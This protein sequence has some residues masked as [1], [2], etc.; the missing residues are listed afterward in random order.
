MHYLLGLRNRERYITGQ[1]KFLNEKF[2]PHEILIYSS[3]LNRTLLSAASQLQG[4][5]PMKEGLGK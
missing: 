2:D 4:L 3:S 5:Y 1:Y